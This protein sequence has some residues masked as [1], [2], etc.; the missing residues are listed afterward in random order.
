MRSLLNRKAV[1]EYALA[2]AKALRP[3]VPFERVG[4]SFIDK[5]EGAVRRAIISEIKLLPSK[6]KTLL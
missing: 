5:I 4:G 2:Q 6:G 3:F 1:K